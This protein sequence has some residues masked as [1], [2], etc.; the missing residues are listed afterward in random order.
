M[1]RISSWVI[2]VDC[3]VEL[4]GGVGPPVLGAV[5]SGILAVPPAVCDAL[6]MAPVGSEVMDRVAGAIF[7]LLSGCMRC[8]LVRCIGEVF[9]ETRKD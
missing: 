7:V 5:V 4:L 2:G 6:P 1:R 3:M 8:E 9:S